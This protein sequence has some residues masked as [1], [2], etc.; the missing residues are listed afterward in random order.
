MLLRRT[1]LKLCPGLGAGVEIE[2]WHS[3]LVQ[4]GS[5]LAMSLHPAAAKRLQQE[6]RDDAD[7][8]KAYELIA[9][10]HET[11]PEAIRIEEE[12]TWRL[13]SQEDRLSDRPNTGSGRFVRDHKNGR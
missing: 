4:A 10:C 2:L 8:R 3:P 13:L 6:F 7:L 12:I 1:R 11:L 9:A 5:P